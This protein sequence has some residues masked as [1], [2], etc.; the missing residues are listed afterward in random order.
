[1]LATRGQVRVLT[2]AGEWLAEFS[3]AGRSVSGDPRAGPE[4]AANRDALVAGFVP[5]V[6]LAWS[7]PDMLRHAVALAGSVSP[8]GEADL[9]AYEAL[10]PEVRVTAPRG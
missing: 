5:G 2:A 3:P 10:L 4:A 8:A 6:A 1:V 9:A 7:W